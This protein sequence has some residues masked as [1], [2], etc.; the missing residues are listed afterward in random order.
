M[1]I[2][3]MHFDHKIP[4]HN[5]EE[6]F[7]FSNQFS[8]NLAKN[9]VKM[10]DSCLNLFGNR[11]EKLWQIWNMGFS[12]RLTNRNMELINIKSL[13]ETETVVL[14]GNRHVHSEQPKSYL[15]TTKRK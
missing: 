15:G 10:V 9:C 14:T 7:K 4:I 8:V 6:N 13:M 2:S 3:E 12:K 11:W 1:N 5:L